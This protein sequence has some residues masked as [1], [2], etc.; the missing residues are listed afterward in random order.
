VLLLL[1]LLLT[2]HVPQQHATHLLFNKS[3]RLLNP[4]L[5]PV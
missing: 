1:L 2:R 4:A 5:P 3:N